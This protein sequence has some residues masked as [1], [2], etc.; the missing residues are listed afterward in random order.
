[1]AN[2]DDPQTGQGEDGGG[3]V[4]IPTAIAAGVAALVGGYLG[5]KAGA[6]GADVVGAIINAASALMA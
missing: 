6:S 5:G 4:N 3:R 1:M 2:E